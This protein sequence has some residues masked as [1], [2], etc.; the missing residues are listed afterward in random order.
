MG[1]RFKWGIFEI[2]FCLNV[3]T[4]IQQSLD[5]SCVSLTCSHMQWSVAEVIPGL[6][7]GTVL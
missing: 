1:C 2:V 7:V 4:E 6:N 3:C 5:Y